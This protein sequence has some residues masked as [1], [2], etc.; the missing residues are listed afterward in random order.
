MGA[1]A[2]MNMI[3]AIVALLCASL[4]LIEGATCTFSNVAPGLTA[5]VT[6]SDSAFGSPTVTSSAIAFGETTYFTCSTGIAQYANILSSSGTSLMSTQ[7]LPAPAF[8][9]Q[10]TNRMYVQRA[11]VSCSS[12]YALSYPIDTTPRQ[13]PSGLVRVFILNDAYPGSVTWQQQTAENPSWTTFTTTAYWGNT[14]VIDTSATAESVSVRCLDS[15]GSV[16][17]STTNQHST[18]DAEMAVNF[19]LIGS[20]SSGYQL[21]YIR[22]CA[23][24]GSNCNACSSGD[25]GIETWLIIVIAVAGVVLLAAAISAIVYFVVCKNKSAAKSDAITSMPESQNIA[26]GLENPAPAQVQSDEKQPEV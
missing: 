17:A 13:V 12:S 4:D 22:N 3:V 6:L 16:I 11:C 23:T 10:S 9:C 14:K 21:A 1:R 15:A 25:S 7:E 18:S 8:S 19:H 24:P 20:Y 26:I 5:Y 2:K